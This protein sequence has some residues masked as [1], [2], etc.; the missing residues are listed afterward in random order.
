MISPRYRPLPT[1][2]LLFTSSAW[3][4]PQNSIAGSFSDYATVTQVT[5]VERHYTIRRPVEKCWNETVRVKQPSSSGSSFTNELIG[6]ILGGGIGNQFGGGH[7]Q[8][9]MTLA[10]AA[11]G[12][13]VANDQ[14]STLP[15]QGQGGHYKEVEHCETIYETE[16]KSEHSHYRVRYHYNGHEFSAKMGRDPG[17]SIQVQVSVTP[18]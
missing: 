13:S 10:G 7:G 14:E 9:A 1:I 15:Q 6:G 18:Q 3:A 17:K 8:D 5:P 4:L 12:A 16:E 2:I 11:L